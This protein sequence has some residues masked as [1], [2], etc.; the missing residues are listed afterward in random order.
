[1]RTR[2]F[3]IF[4]VFILSSCA[5]ERESINNISG[6]DEDV[7]SFTLPDSIDTDTRASL[8]TSMPDQFKVYAYNSNGTAVI[9][10][11]VFTKSGT[12]WT[13]ST[14]HL[15]P[16]SGNLTFYA[17]YPYD[18]TSVVSF[19]TS[20]KQLSY[21]P[22][23]VNVQSDLIYAYNSLSRPANGGPV[24]LTF[25]RA[26]A[27][28]SVAAQL[29]GSAK[30][31]TV[32]I[33]SIQLCNVI[34]NNTLT[35]F[36]DGNVASSGTATNY[37]FAMA[38]NPVSLSTTPKSISST[39]GYLLVP[40][41]TLTAWS[42]TGSLSNSYFVITGKVIVGNYYVIGSPSTNGTWYIPV[43][44]TLRKGEINRI[45]L[46][47]GAKNSDGSHIFGYTA[48]GSAIRYEQMPI[49]TAIDLGLSVKWASFNLG[50]SAPEEYG[51]F[52]AFGDTKGYTDSENHEF[53]WTTTPFCTNTNA[54]SNASSWSKYNTDN[55]KLE[56]I[57]DAAT[58][59]L[60]STWR[61]PTY[62]ECVELNTKCTWT[63]TTQN[64]VNG[65]LITGTNGNSI[66][67]PAA[68][69]RAT[70]SG[71]EGGTYGWYWS[72]QIGTGSN[73]NKGWHWTFDNKNNHNITLGDGRFTGFS[74]RAVQP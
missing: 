59:N 55:A 7:I 71:T 27:A 1:M 58:V 22:G 10:G 32:Q 46:T 73:I 69:Y 14:E 16:T 39:T 70:G 41:Q 28:V 72:S 47:L 9:N 45:V 62:D 63:W 52:Y 4:F 54:T 30:Y 20:T 3:I 56:S 35:S 48:S 65:Y 61:M 51:Y 57:D 53:S 8:V 33:A 74:I 37:Q 18:N 49:P 17:Y 43:G 50:A 13:S 34:P 11:E 42:H 29:A 66:F 15:W 5:Q 60:G 36:V 44:A 68:G 2:F 67:F 6:S 24:P 31:T 23:N 38:S 19:S 12:I 25:N 21:T 26:L 64:G 40:A